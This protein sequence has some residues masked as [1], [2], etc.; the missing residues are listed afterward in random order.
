MPGL[1]FMVDYECSSEQ[2]CGRSEI[3]E[4]KKMAINKLS[5]ELFHRITFDDVY[6]DVTSNKNRN[7]NKNKNCR[8]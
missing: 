3:L 1:M 6:G 8:K 7:R 2:K 5:E 4:Y